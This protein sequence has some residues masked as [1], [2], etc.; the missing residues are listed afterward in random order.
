MTVTNLVS[1]CKQNQC[2]AC[3]AWPECDYGRL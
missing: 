1:S 3:H 2:R